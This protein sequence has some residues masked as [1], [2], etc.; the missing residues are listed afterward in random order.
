MS[1]VKT[2]RA[3]KAKT[4]KTTQLKAVNRPAK[5]KRCPLEFD[6]AQVEYL[7]GL[8]LSQEKIALKLGCSERTITNRLNQD[9]NFAAAYA[10]GKVS[11]E[12]LVASKLQERIED[13]DTTAI[14]FYLST[15]CD[16]REASKVDATVN[17]KVDAKVEHDVKFMSDDEL[18]RLAAMDKA[19]QDGGNSY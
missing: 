5:A 12:V 7:A 18:L 11:R 4:A 6:Y 1:T 9:A 13:G 8:G 10:R 3:P 19:N 16:W 14:K 15:Q 2:K 17:A